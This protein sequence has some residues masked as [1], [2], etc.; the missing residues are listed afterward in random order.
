MDTNDIV[1]YCK[2]NK[3]WDDIISL[4]EALDLAVNREARKLIF[5][6]IHELEYD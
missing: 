2:K 6:R 4:I 1:A 3:L 5:A